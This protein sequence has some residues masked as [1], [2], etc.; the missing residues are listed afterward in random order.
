MSGPRHGSPAHST[1]ENPS[2]R[3]KGLRRRLSVAFGV[4]ALAAVL[5]PRADAW[6]PRTHLILAE[7]AARLAPPDLARLI[8]RHEG[9]FRRGTQAP[10]EDGAPARHVQ[11]ADGTGEL[12]ATIQRETERAVRMI[13]DLAPFEEVVFQLGVVAHYVADAH[14]VLATSD[15]D[16]EEPR[17]RADFA[18]Y[19]ESAQGRFPFVFYGFWRGFDEPRHVAGLVERAFARGRGQYALVGREY[20]RIGFVSGVGRFDDRSTAFG[21]ASV[22]F[23]HAASDIAQVLRYIWLRSGGGDLRPDLP[24]RGETLLKVPRSSESR[25]ILPRSQRLPR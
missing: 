5:A 11:N 2:K 25:D 21:V 14:D 8:E 3:L 15:A 18:R 22:S 16:G 9:A 10:F 23:S 12:G 24:W 1:F 19:V 13:R 7:E 6:T 20:R 17:Y 4:L